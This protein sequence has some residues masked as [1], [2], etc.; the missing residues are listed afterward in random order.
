MDYAKEAL[1]THKQKK[2][3]L[4]IRP[5]FPLNTKHDLSVAYTPGVAAVAQA[6]AK[7]QKSAYDYTGKSHFVAIV[8]DGS[9]VLGLG[10]IGPYAALPVMEGKAALFKRFANI[11]AV[12][13]CLEVKDSIEVIPIVKAIAPSF[14]AI[15]LEDIAAPACFRV[16][17]QLQDIGIPVI[18]DDQHG[19]AVV[20]LAGLMNA[21]KVVRKRMQGIKVVI[22]G[23]GAAGT[24]IA[25]I[26]L[27]QN[28]KDI[29]L[30]DTKGMIYRGRKYDMGPAKQE[31]ARM[32]N[33][34]RLKGNLADALKDADVL[35]GVSVGNVTSASMIRSMA[36]KPI[37][38]ALANPVP[39]I[40][41][42][43]AKKAGA[44]IVAT[45][46]SD[47]DNQINNVLA[48]PGIFK[49]ALQARAKRI[50]EKMKLA[51]AHAI[52]S[53]VRPSAGNIVPSPFDKGLHE[54]VAKAVSQ[55]V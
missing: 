18:H 6:I 48:F 22:N 46:R 32:T 36:A 38:F 54:R 23:A 21:L 10:G 31:I 43:L 7:D 49:G 51:A 33:K 8:T 25:K 45:G 24:A 35:I 53:S 37:V 29:I 30:C 3:I 44:A 41:P 47:H 15:M 42:A 39:E 13:I 26:L 14:G 11:D 2:G 40:D 27:S 52:A 17:Q 5:T 50:T 28:I 19:T 20:A 16:E 1:R 34:D 4:S 12:P 55:A 9:K